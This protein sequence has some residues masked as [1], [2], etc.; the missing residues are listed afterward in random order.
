[1]HQISDLISLFDNTFY[2][3]YQTRLIRGDDEPIYLP[4]DKEH[5]FH[6]IIFAHG[7]Y[8]SGMHEISHW[9]I[10]GEKRRLI[11]DY[12]Y[13]YCPDGRTTKE[14]AEFEK[15]EIKPQA[16]E[17]ALC[18]AAGFKFN[19]SADNLN[20]EQPCRMM[21]QNKVHNQV[22]KYL[23]SGFCQRTQQLLKAFSDFYQTPWPLTEHRF[24][25]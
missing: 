15:V 14:Q 6:R 2:Q 11:E 1:M 20:G 22:L 18:I 10:A 13:W 24:N 23:E 4:A 25:W 21:F 8:S 9:L 12:G 3:N 7:Y 5:H 17:W 16:I 19:V